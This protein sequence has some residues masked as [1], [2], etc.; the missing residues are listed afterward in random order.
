MPQ[1]LTHVRNKGELRDNRLTSAFPDD[2]SSAYCVW[3]I[4]GNDP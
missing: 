4:K 3:R 2:T 1:T